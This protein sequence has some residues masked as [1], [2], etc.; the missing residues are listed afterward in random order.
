MELLRL[1]NINYPIAV[2]ETFK[3]V[4]PFP[5]P[6]L[7]NGHKFFD[8]DLSD[9]Q[10]IPQIFLDHEFTAF[11]LNNHGESLAQMALFVF[12]GFLLIL[13]NRFN[14]KK[15]LSQNEQSSSS[16]LEFDDKNKKVTW[17]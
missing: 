9:R 11:L 17:L 14:Q 6:F 5:P 10:A 8:E 12:I 4:V 13:I 15:N 7:F 16:S 2:Q 1:Q 3:E